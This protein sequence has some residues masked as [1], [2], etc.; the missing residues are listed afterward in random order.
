ME[1]NPEKKLLQC[2]RAQ[3]SRRGVL[4]WVAVK[5]LDRGHQTLDVYTGKWVE[6]L[7]F[8]VY[9]WRLTKS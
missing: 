7:G 1:L 6:G 9:G 8:G 2:K 5:E 3:I 4:Y